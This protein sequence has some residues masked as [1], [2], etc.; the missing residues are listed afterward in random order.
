MM[1][2]TLNG[3]PFKALVRGPAALYP[4][5]GLWMFF[6]WYAIAYVAFL[7]GAKPSRSFAIVAFV[8]FGIGAG[9]L[10]WIMSRSGGQ[11]FEASST[12]IR[13]GRSGK[14][15]ELPWNEIQ[16][17]RISAVKRGVLLEVML[18]PSVPV[19]YRG[20]GR[21][22]G[23]LAFFSLPVTGVRRCTPALLVPL[24]D[25][26]RYRVPLIRVTAQELSNALAG[27]A[28]GLPVSVG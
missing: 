7:F 15:R 9:G 19:A 22:L 4:R 10:T 3:T 2:A 16:Q 12:G 6:V 27:L 17:L 5:G 21:Q 11:S 25:P 24:P 13:L 14:V 28:P 1:A 20:L 8:M 23:D 18:S 26:P